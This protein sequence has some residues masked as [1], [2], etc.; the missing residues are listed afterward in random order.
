MKTEPM[1]FDGGCTCA[2]VRYRMTTKP[3]F[4]H[5]CHCRWCQRETG[6]AFALN[7]LIEAEQVILLRGHPE[8]VLTPS[9]SGEGQ[10]I[11]RC[12]RCRIAVWSHYAGSGAALCFVRVGTLDAPDRFPP[13][14][15][16]FTE[17]KQPWLVL[18]PAI[19][20][21]AQY[22][23]ASEHWPKESLERYAALQRKSH[24]G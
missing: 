10:S 5:C 3:M 2:M 6:A 9:N 8:T 15:H 24:P 18:G 7:A 19:P 14:I 17:S 22:Y 23:R 20:A 11:V 21:V 12:P 4:V 16:I 13:D 1:E